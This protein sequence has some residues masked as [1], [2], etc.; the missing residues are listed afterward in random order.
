MLSV[1]LI[2]TVYFSESSSYQT[3]NLCVLDCVDQFVL[4]TLCLCVFMCIS[5]SLRLQSKIK[6]RFTKSHSQLPVLLSLSALFFLYTPL[7]IV[8]LFVDFAFSGLISPDAPLRMYFIQTNKR[9]ALRPGG[10]TFPGI[11]IQLVNIVSILISLVFMQ[12]SA[13][14]RTGA[15]NF[16]GSGCFEFTCVCVRMENQCIAC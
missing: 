9:D 16:N 1:H 6:P 3:V 7:S 10:R 4:Q 5:V 11:S 8:L 13:G 15:T 12:V 2:L 14:P